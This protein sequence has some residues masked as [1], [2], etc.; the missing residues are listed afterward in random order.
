VTDPRFKGDEFFDS[1][2][3]VQVRYEMV[4]RVEVEGAPVAE[5]ARAFGCSRPTFYKVKE[6]LVSEG[7][8]GQPDPA[9]RGVAAGF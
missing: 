4:R 9:N 8:S 7:L 5:T 1:R 3:L 6:A 2:D